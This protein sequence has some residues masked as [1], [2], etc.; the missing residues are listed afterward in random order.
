MADNLK[1]L[2]KMDD[3]FKKLREKLLQKK[4]L[5]WQDKKELEKM[6]EEQKKLPGDKE[7]DK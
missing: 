7:K 5:D 4:Q 6:L 1:K 3:R 2:D